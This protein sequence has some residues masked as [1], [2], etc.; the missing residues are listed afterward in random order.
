MFQLQLQAPD[1][2]IPL[3]RLDWRPTRPH[4]N[5]H[6][7]PEHQ[8]RTFRGSHYHPFELNRDLGLD[9]MVQ[10]RLP[11]AV[12]LDPDPASFNELLIRMG[13]LFAIVGVER[14]GLPEWSPSLF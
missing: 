10:E 5:S 2:F 9:V 3:R 4:T 13:Q 8:F 14:I 6:G 11:V 12:D 1:G 7:G